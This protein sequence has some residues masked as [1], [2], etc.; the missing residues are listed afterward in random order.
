LKK[1]TPSVSP[2]VERWPSGRRRSPAKGVC[3]N[4]VSRVRIPGYRR[5]QYQKPCFPGPTSLIQFFPNDDPKMLRT[6]SKG[7]VLRP[8]GPY[9][10]PDLFDRWGLARA[11]PSTPYRC[12][13]KR[14][15]FDILNV[16]RSIAEIREGVRFAIRLKYF[17]GHVK[18][19]GVFF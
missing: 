6:P 13:S 18:Y 15:H 17:R 8:T 12:I 19:I 4:P 2:Q 5:A 3:G 1:I 10:D 14:E 7:P 9:L 16:N 11:T